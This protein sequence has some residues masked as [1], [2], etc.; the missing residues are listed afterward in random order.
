MGGAPHE[1]RCRGDP[2]LALRWMLLVSLLVGTASM[3]L[4]GCQTKPPPLSRGD[5]APS[6]RLQ[7]RGGD[8]LSF[9]EDVGSRPALL[10]FW[11][12]SCPY[13]V[14]E[15]RDIEAL[16]PD[17]EK[18]GLSV[19]AINVGESHD[20]ADAMEEDTLV[21]YPVLFDNDS[22]VALRYGVTVY[23]AALVIDREGNVYRKIVG[24]MSPEVLLAMVEDVL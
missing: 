17:L 6:F 21:T 12:D 22:R 23:P 24:R 13:C 14:E 7:A 8:T 18:R 9:P 20:A 19:L 11:T 16:L 3:G 1:V 2:S 4:A 10:L 5:P 15:M